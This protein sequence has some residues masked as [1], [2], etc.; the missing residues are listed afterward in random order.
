MVS[1][2]FNDPNCEYVAEMKIHEYAISTI[3]WIYFLFHDFCKGFSWWPKIV[4]WCLNRKLAVAEKE[5]YYEILF[6]IG[7]YLLCFDDPSP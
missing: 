4:G 3:R 2:F 6:I 5:I 7:L 1:M